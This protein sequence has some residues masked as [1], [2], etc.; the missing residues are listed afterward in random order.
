M[1]G[2]DGHG[3]GSC[4]TSLA[5]RTG[6]SGDAGSQAARVLFIA[7]SLIWMRNSSMLSTIATR[8][9]SC[10]GMLR[11]W[12][13]MSSSITTAEASAGRGKTT[14]TRRGEMSAAVSAG[15]RCLEVSRSIPSRGLALLKGTRNFAISSL[16]NALAKRNSRSSGTRLPTDG[17]SLEYSAAVI[18]PSDDPAVRLG[19]ERLLS[20]CVVASLRTTQARNSGPR[21]PMPDAVSFVQAMAFPRVRR[22]A[23]FPCVDALLPPSP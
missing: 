20:A 9:A 15:S 11:S 16:Q 19:P 5:G 7:P 4:R 1:W 18:A 3:S 21:E 17:S 23:P 10:K 14:S 2:V 22:C 12:T 6:G 8:L 13:P